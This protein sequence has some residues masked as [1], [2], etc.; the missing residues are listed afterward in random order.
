MKAA[1]ALADQAW[2]RGGLDAMQEE[3]ASLHRTEACPV[4]IAEFRRL[5]HRQC[6]RALPTDE[7]LDFWANNGLVWHG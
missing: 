3:L 5:Y 2:L 1:G 6:L 4:L 7:A